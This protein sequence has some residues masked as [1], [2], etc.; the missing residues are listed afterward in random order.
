MEIHGLPIS[1]E[2]PIFGECGD[3]LDKHISGACL[4]GAGASTLYAVAVK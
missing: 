1:D 2:D 3:E 4:M